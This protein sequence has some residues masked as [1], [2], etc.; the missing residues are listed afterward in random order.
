VQDKY[1]L[2]ESIEEHYEES[3]ELDY[4]F[5]AGVVLTILIVLALFMPKIYIANQIYFNSLEIAKLS[6]ERDMLREE[7]QNLKEALIKKKFLS[8]I[9]KQQQP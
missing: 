3:E 1:E 8:T 2:L 6:K 4:H 9:E 5:L 7:H